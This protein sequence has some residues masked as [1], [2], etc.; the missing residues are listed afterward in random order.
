MVEPSAV[1]AARGAHWVSGRQKLLGVGAVDE[2]VAQIRSIRSTPGQDHSAAIGGNRRRVLEVASGGQRRDGIGAERQLLHDAAGAI[3]D[4]H[5]VTADVIATDR[6]QFSRD[7]AL[8]RTIGVHQPQVVDA[9][10]R[11]D[12]GDLV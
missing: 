5:A 3:H 2:P 6:H 11:G 4:C 12:E 1:K 7:L 10:S 8:V 9:T